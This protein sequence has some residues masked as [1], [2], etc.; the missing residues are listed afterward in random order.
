[1]KK[2]VQSIKQKLHSGRGT[3]FAKM[4]MLL[5][6]ASLLTAVLSAVVYYSIGIRIF[7]QRIADEMLPRAYSIARVSER[8]LRGRMDF[9][10]Y[11]SILL[12]DYPHET[13]IFIYDD[14]GNLFVRSVVRNGRSE[15]NDPPAAYNALV[16]HILTT[17][18]PITD[19]SRA[20]TRGG[21]VL[22]GVVVGVPILDNLQRVC[23]A[24]LL[25]KPS[26]ELH[27][28][29]GS[30][31]FALLVSSLIAIVVLS[32]LAFFI[33]RRFVKPLQ[34]MAKIA[35]SMASGDFSSKTDTNLSGEVGQLGLA[36]NFLSEELSNTISE[37]TRTKNH[38]T[39]TLKG[40]NEGVVSLNSDLVVT[41]CNPA[42]EQLI[43]KQTRHETISIEGN[44]DQFKEQML[45]VCNSVL[46]SGEKSDILIR[47]AGRVLQFTAT[48]SLPFDE[49]RAEL[50][51]MI[52]DITEAERLE[53]TRREYVANVSHEL[54]TPIASIRSLAETLNDGMIHDDS[55]KNRYYGHIL[56]ESMRLSRLIDDLL[57][58]SRLQSGAIALTKQPFQLNDL[59]GDVAE[60]AKMQA[61]Y[62]G[63]TVRFEEQN[64]SLVYSNP[65]R[66]EQ[67]L[68]AL[69]DNAIKYTV[70][71][72]RIRLTAYETSDHVTVEI[73]NTGHIAEEDLPHLFDRFYK[74]DKAHSG[75]GTG[76]GLAI[77]KELLQLLGESIEV[78]ND[79]E[80]VVFSFTVALHTD[81]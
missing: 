50:I 37:L 16:N 76:L 6:L 57:E 48:R 62:S 33:S 51:L 36:L 71:D 15:S 5:I 44:P 26:H 2:S 38:L 59:L 8:Y 70:D 45:A 35:V 10:S 7:G 81:G 42:A 56:R 79:G 60:R 73:F 63:I 64:L 12:D 52:R 43:G 58:L 55:V 30:M 49:T 69:I 32:V 29:M 22:L 65:D 40:L 39:T 14:Q 46:L 66:I 21:R 67:I 41:F 13:R 53:Q 75:Q 72:G 78:R 47:H 77:T 31:L 24:V 61:E 28:A 1:M 18:E 9:D 4:T 19:S 3:L 27:A 11:R 54:R 25:T 17:G 23:G 80:D 74:A 68:I 34:N 20:G